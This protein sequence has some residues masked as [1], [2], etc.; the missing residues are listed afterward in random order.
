[1]PAR[2]HAFDLARL[3][4]TAGEGRRFSLVVPLEPIELS[5]QRYAVPGGEAPVDLSIS[6]MTANG[7]ALRLQFAASLSGPCMRCLEPADLTVEVEARE[8]D[9]PGDVEDLD[10]PYV[11]G[12]AVDLGAW[13]R[14][15]LVLALPERIL[16]REDCAGLCAVCGADLNRDPGH[17]H[18]PV[19]DPRWAKLDDVTWPNLAESAT[20]RTADA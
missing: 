7:H 4:L 8:V 6:R 10:S 16:C 13:A 11:D 9:Q 19:R 2:T 14:D 17:A 15:A 1:M 18:E 3:R 5:G 20:R 12:G